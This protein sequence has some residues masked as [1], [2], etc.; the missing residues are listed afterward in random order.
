MILVLPVIDRRIEA[1]FIAEWFGYV[2]AIDDEMYMPLV[3]SLVY[4][5]CYI[6]FGTG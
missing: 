3:G 4:L 2:E 5:L 6:E 1:G